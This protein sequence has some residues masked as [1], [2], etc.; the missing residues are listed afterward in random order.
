MRRKDIPEALTNLALWPS[1]DVT[2]LDADSHAQYRLREDAIHA[3]FSGES[4]DS[5]EERLGAKRGTLYWF[6]ERCITPHPDGRIQGF[7]GLIPFAHVKPYVRVKPPKARSVRGGLVG[8][9]NQ[10]LDRYPSLTGIVRRHIASGELRLTLTNR[11]VG[12]RQLQDAF[13]ELPCRRR[14][15]HASRLASLH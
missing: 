13:L 6:I 5:I 3:Y 9:F 14:S 2:A 12:L 8:A 10:L 11:L 7:R 1:I 4:L 15:C